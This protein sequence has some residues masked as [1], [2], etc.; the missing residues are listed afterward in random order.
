MTFGRFWSCSALVRLLRVLRFLRWLVLPMALAGCAAVAPPPIAQEARLRGD[1]IALLGE[2]HDNAEGH[3]VRVAMLQ[4]AIAAG[5]RPA[6]AMEQFDLPR[7]ADIDRARR[8]AP[9]DA[10]HVIDVAAAS[11]SGWDWALYRP[12][13]A[14]AL[15]HDLPLLAAN[16]SNADTGKIVRGGYGDVFDADRLAAL[17][18]DQP[19]APDWQATQ[20]REIDAGHCGLLPATMWP[21]MARAQ[22]ARDA[23]MADV[24]RQHAEQG[25]VLIAGNGHVRRDIGVAR[26]LGAAE[27]PR[28]LAVGF[29]EAPDDSLVS[30]GA[31]DAVVRV[32][33]ASR[34]DPCATLKAR[35]PP[36]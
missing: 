26:R 13:I 12:V 7:Q 28:V 25:V 32:P 34:A 22:F 17:G 27:L 9:H 15:D 4:R 16:L 10:Q 11:G 6:I 19:V 29:L 31:Y 3:R 5:W 33:P 20:E 23:V 35:R 2:I 14:L 18:L 30:A 36:S 8:E 1:T 24:L 21:A